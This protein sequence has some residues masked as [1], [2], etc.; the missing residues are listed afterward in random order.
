MVFSVMLYLCSRIV[1]PPDIPVLYRIVL[2]TLGLLLFHVKLSIVL[3]RSV[4][5]FTG[6]L[7]G[8]ALNL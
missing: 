1:M 5:N 2:A 8:S 3:S 4:K 6:I 7:M